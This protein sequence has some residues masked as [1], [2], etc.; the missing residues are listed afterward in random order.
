MSHYILPLAFIALVYF[1]MIVLNER[2]GLFATDRFPSPLAKIAA[3]LW[4][5]LL[6]FGLCIEIVGASM[7]VPT[8]REL[9]RVP[10]YSLFL[11][12]GILIVFLLGWWLLTGRPPLRD[13][14]S[15]RGGNKGEM[16]MIGF[17]VGIGGWIFTLVVA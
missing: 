12:H 7:H 11:L 1:A 3:Y 2:Y 10:F 15:L 17:A 9:A 16:V 4:L 6:L 14:L 8:A 13:F 5:G